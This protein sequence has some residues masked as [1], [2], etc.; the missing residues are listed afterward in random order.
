MNSLSVVEDPIYF[1]CAAMTLHIASGFGRFPSKLELQPDGLYSDF[2]PYEQDMFSFRYQASQPFNSFSYG[3]GAIPV[4]VHFPDSLNLFLPEEIIQ[5]QCTRTKLHCRAVLTYTQFN[6]SK[7]RIWHLTLTP[8]EGV[9]FSHFDLIKLIK[10]YAGPH[11]GIDLKSAIMFSSTDISPQ[12]IS[13]FMH[14]LCNG[15]HYTQYQV[16]GGGLL[17]DTASSTYVPA[18]W[19]IYHELYF[20]FSND[21]IAMKQLEAHIDGNGIEGKV[22]RILCGIISG[23]LVYS[24]L[25]FIEIK[26]IL[27]PTIPDINQLIRLHRG[28]LAV[29]LKNAPVTRR[30]W[31]TIGNSPYIL[32]YQALLLQNDMLVNIADRKLCRLLDKSKISLREA[33]QLRR[34]I[35]Q[36]LNHQYLPNVFHYSTD[37]AIYDRGSES[38][39][40]FDKLN[41]T[42]LRLKDLVTRIQDIR[43]FRTARAAY[44]ISILLALLSVLQVQ[45][46]VFAFF[47]DF[48]A[49]FPKS[50]LIWWLLFLVVLLSVIAFVGYTLHPKRKQE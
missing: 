39:G 35:D 42:K 41:A 15:D 12:K 38:R 24:D 9:A 28:T 25:S 36:M 14:A 23:A 21:S 31:D 16:L 10:L 32:I 7:M 8:A 34:E 20:A 45:Q 4:T 22:L 1:G 6:Q 26:D 48:N 27:H 37:R 33:E 43:A 3:Q 17:L 18:G 2:Q 11:E 30:V 29:F 46:T 19:N 5:L 40:S 13:E 44:Y 47:N 49:G 50:N